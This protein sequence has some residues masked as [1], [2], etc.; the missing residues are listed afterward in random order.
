M[1]KNNKQA[2]GKTNSKGKNKGQSTSKSR[3]KPDQHKSLSQAQEELTNPPEQK[4]V[5]QE[6]AD[7]KPEEASQTQASRPYSHYPPPPKYDDVSF[8]PVKSTRQ[9]SVLDEILGSW[10]P[11]E[12]DPE[13][14]DPGKSEVDFN[15]TKLRSRY[16]NWVE[17]VHHILH[18]P[19]QVEKVHLSIQP[20]P[21][22]FIL[23]YVFRLLCLDTLCAWSPF[24]T[25]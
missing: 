20:W 22:V 6:K 11:H 10:N 17:N 1:K 24:C 8:D 23:F 15:H 18:T 16:L 12:V 5:A 25:L 19:P 3:D 13:Y 21:V 7:A 2:N 9:K 4:P 14:D